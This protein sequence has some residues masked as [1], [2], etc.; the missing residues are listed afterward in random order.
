MAVLI[1][2]DLAR[3]PGARSNDV[4]VGDAL[5]R[6]LPDEVWICY[7]SPR[8]SSRPAFV[9][10]APSYGVVGIDVCDWS[11]IDVEPT[12]DGGLRIAGGTVADPVADLGQKLEALRQQVR[13]IRPEPPISGLLVFPSFKESELIKRGFA[14]YLRPGTV[15]A[16]DRLART[17]LE[18]SLRSVSKPLGASTI[19]EIRSRLYPDTQ[20]ERSRLVRDEGRVKR[21]TFRLQLDADQ[22]SIARALSDG[23]TLVSGVTGSGKSLVLCARARLLAAEHP[24]WSIQVLCYNRTLVRYLRELVGQD[25]VQVEIDTFYAWARRMG[26]HLPSARGGDDEAMK[27][28]IERAITRGTA[29]ETYDAVL[30]DEGQ[31]FAPS[32]LKFAYHTVTPGRGGMVVVCDMA[33][34]IYREE[35]FFDI[36]PREQV[37]HVVLPRNYRNTA[38]VGCFAVA[39]VFGDQGP[40]RPGGTTTG[41]GRSPPVAEFVLTGPPVQLVWAERWDLQAAFIA[42][43]I[44]RIVDERRAA[45]R[46]IAVLYTQRMGTVKRILPALDEHKIPYFWVNQDK[47]AKT[48]VDFSENSVKVMTVHSCKGLEFPVVFIFGL[49]ALRVPDSLVEA[50]TEEANRTRVAYVGMTRA[51]D[52]LYLTYTRTNP[53]IDRALGLGKWAEFH[54]YP[55]DFDFE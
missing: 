49:E 32:W 46:D 50:S 54:S 52:L 31:D 55:E 15:V 9:L 38:Q 27:D 20:F 42:R 11:P 7:N 22:E 43:E 2:R 34:A 6:A 18:K 28:S 37:A 41:D 25:K 26:L 24:D 40:G 8:R 17:G 10:I 51:Q 29:A 36:F 48:T 21:Q 30:V 4:L 35:T 33:Q 45:Y 5:Q 53:V 16:G 1:P 14:E 3:A 19:Q 39:A 47:D 44:R 23:I 12:K 13:S